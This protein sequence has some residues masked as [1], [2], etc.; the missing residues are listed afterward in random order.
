MTTKREDEQ[1]LRQLAY[2][3]ARLIDRRDWELIPLAL[4]KTHAYRVQASR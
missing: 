2:R 1:E 4:A 3:Y